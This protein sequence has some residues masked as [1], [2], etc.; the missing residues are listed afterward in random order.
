MLVLRFLKTYKFLQH[1]SP[2]RSFRT[3]KA[4]AAGA[5][6]DNILATLKTEREKS[7]NKCVSYD[8]INDYDIRS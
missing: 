2:Y 7:L 5:H 3:M 1:E 6:M 4:S 8:I